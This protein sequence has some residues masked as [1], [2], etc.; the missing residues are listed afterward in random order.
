MGNHNDKGR[1]LQK[2][3]S[4]SKEKKGK[5][6]RFVASKIHQENKDISIN[7]PS[8]CLGEPICKFIGPFSK[9]TSSLVDSGHT[10][11]G[12]TP[13]ESTKRT[14]E[15]NHINKLRMRG[16]EKSSFSA[17][18][19]VPSPTNPVNLSTSQIYELDCPCGESTS[20][21]PSTQVFRGVPQ[22]AVVQNSPLY[23]SAWRCRGDNHADFNHWPRPGVIEIDSSFRAGAMTAKNCDEI[24]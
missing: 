23:L 10:A 4:V 2:P 8:C 13:G 6:K 22:G 16:P 14:G 15:R 17:Q 7:L 3:Y 11:F 9:S 19:L 18:G 12:S 21:R 20:C 24:P 1:S 5:K